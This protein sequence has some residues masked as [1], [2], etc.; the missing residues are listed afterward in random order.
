MVCKV[1]KLSRRNAFDSPNVNINIGR[2]LLHN[3]NAMVVLAAYTLLRNEARCVL[4]SFSG[5]PKSITFMIK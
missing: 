5:G 2:C 1:L 3:I 4:F